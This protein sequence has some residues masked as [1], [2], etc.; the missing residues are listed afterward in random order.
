MYKRNSQ[1]WLK[2][3]DFILLD[4]LVLQAVF[5]LAYI[6]R[7]GLSM[8]YSLGAYRT[9][10]FWLIAADILVAAIFNSMHNVLK[11]GPYKEFIQDIQA[12]DHV[13]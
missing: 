5:I 11:R 4:V 12:Q 9:L 10:G 8:P 1:G 13:P 7:H 3:I 2:H 6:L